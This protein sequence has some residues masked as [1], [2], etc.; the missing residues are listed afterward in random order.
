MIR[1]RAV[2]GGALALPWPARASATPTAPPPMVSLIVGS[3]PGRGADLAARAFAPFLERHLRQVRIAVLNRPGEI[4]LTALRLL[5]DAEPGARAIGWVSSPTLPA[6]MVDRPGAAG[7]A[8]RLHLVG[9]VQKEP[10]VFVSAAGTKL[11]SVSDLLHRASENPAARP[12][13]TPPQGSAGH[14]AALRL[15]AV[16]HP[17]LNILAFPSAAAAREAAEA[18]HAA[19][20][21][22]ALADV[23]DGLREGSLS[24]LGIAAKRPSRAIPDVAPLHASGI[25]LTA[26]ILRGIATPAG[27]PEI[28]IAALSAALRGIVADPEFL[29]AAT[30]NGFLPDLLDGPDW[31]A[32]VSRERAELAGLWRTAPWTAAPAG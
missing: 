2:L 30:E 32:Q 23:L 31:T 14:L 25:A 1:R 6:R 20:A 12:L 4:G 3:H 26:A 11:R 29:A 15:Q 8:D 24:G 10:I 9:A 13:A 5:A 22:L 27:A 21:A 28:W 7:L 18:G 16:S 17:A 19:A